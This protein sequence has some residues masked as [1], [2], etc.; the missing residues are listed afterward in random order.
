MIAKQDIEE[1]KRDLVTLEIAQ[2]LGTNK[3][4]NLNGTAIDAQD[5]AS[6]FQRNND[7]LKNIR[8]KKQRNGFLFVPKKER[9]H[10]DGFVEYRRLPSSLILYFVPFIDPDD[11]CR[12]GSGGCVSIMTDRGLCWFCVMSDP[13][14]KVQDSS[15]AQDSLF[16][17]KDHA[18]RRAIERSPIKN[19]EMALGMILWAM[20]KTKRIE[21]TPLGLKM[22]EDN[23]LII[24]TAT[25]VIYSSFGKVVGTRFNT[26]FYKGQGLVL[27]NTYLSDDMY[28]RGE[29]DI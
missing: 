6:F 28:V 1:I 12:V 26:A 3:F 7:F 14:S 20:F 25:R 19:Y 5:R 22:Q 24:R 23:K 10:F 29:F 13:L 21:H 27:I 4:I 16:V 18:I 8:S 15:I 9:V 17:V 11:V 2:E